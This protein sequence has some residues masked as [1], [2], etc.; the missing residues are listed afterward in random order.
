MN[1]PLRAV[2]DVGTAFL[3]CAA[4]FAL[5]LLVGRSRV[6]PPSGETWHRL[7]DARVRAGGHVA[8]SDDAVIEVVMFTDYYCESCARM[9]QLLEDAREVWGDALAVRYRHYPLTT[10]HPKSMSA[11]TFLE[12]AAKRGQLYEAQS[13]AF[14]AA[15]GDTVDW[16]AIGARMGGADSADFLACMADSATRAAVAH[17][18]GHAIALGLRGTPAVVVDDRVYYTPVVMDS[19]GRRLASSRDSHWPGAGR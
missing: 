14:R 11:A 12:C 19:I 13:T 8:G 9:F 17:D 15:A 5:G 18:R 16:L 4:T 3:M 7:A 10:A 1:V 2:L 6:E